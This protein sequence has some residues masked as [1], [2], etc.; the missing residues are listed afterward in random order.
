MVDNEGKVGGRRK[1][2]GMFAPSRLGFFSASPPSLSSI[3]PTSSSSSST[4]LLSHESS[5]DSFP[6]Y[7][8]ISSIISTISKCLLRWM[9]RAASSCRRS[10]P[11][12]GPVTIAAS[13]ATRV[14]PIA[15]TLQAVAPA[16]QQSLLGI[17]NTL[18]P[19]L[20]STPAPLRSSCRRRLTRRSH[21][22]ARCPT[23][24]RLPCLL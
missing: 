15:I 17:I 7:L 20:P 13:L 23:P 2:K 24:A 8:C 16:D 5:Y 6:D 14:G 9:P 21:R 22:P 19:L 12:R 10:L 18:C 1:S 3:H 4:I 11:W